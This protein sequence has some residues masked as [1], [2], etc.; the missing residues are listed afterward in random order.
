MS[1][2]RDKAR[3]VRKGAV[4]FV[5]V[6]NKE[7]YLQVKPR[8]SWWSCVDQHHIGQRSLAGVLVIAER[9]FAM[10]EDGAS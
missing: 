6:R 10:L 1:P 2:F 3:I 9:R 8:A 4:T 7:M 5:I